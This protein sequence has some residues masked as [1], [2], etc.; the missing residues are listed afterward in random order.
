MITPWGVGVDNDHDRYITIIT[1]VHVQYPRCM[2]W[3]EKQGLIEY[4]MAKCNCY[5]TTL[6]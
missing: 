6:S 5:L 3:F 1:C 4:I 2:G